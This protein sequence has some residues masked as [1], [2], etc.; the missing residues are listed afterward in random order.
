MLPAVQ[1]F[2]DALLGRQPVRAYALLSE[3]CRARLSLDDF[4]NTEA[5]ANPT[6][7]KARQI[8]Y[9]DIAQDGAT[10]TVTF[11]YTARATNPKHQTWVSEH[12]HWRN[13]DC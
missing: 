11:D 9:A 5:N 12:G 1:A 8:R 6:N 2:S 3:R 13:D 4:T 10:A 7:G